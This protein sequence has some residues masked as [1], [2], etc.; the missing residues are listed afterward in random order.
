MY[1]VLRGIG[2]IGIGIL[3]SQR[4]ERPVALNVSIL[5]L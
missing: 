2:F 5:F 1:S 4:R 3:H